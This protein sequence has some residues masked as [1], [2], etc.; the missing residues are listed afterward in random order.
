M[1]YRNVPVRT[2]STGG[3]HH[4]SLMDGN[5]YTTGFLTRVVDPEGVV[6]YLRPLDHLFWR[7]LC[8][9]RIIKYCAEPSVRESPE[10]EGSL[11]RRVRFT[12]YVVLAG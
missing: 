2:T 11:Q 10:H 4:H 7:I 9:I 3:A 12:S 1:K 8:Q 6:Y 5:V